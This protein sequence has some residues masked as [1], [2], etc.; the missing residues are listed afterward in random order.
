MIAHSV[1]PRLVSSSGTE[2]CEIF[3]GVSSE[4]QIGCRTKASLLWDAFDSNSANSAKPTE[5]EKEVEMMDNELK[6]YWQ[7]L[8]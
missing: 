3:G 6:I 7:S 4:G 5:K 8:L 1:R 2:G